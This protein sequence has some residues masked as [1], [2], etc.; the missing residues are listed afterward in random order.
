MKN[1]SNAD[2]ESIREKMLKFA[3]L[4]LKDKS[5]AEDMVQEAFVSALKNLSSFKRQSALKTWMFA[6]LKNKIID[7]LRTNQRF[8][9]ESDLV[10]EEEQENNFFERGMWRKEYRPSYLQEDENQIY[11]AQFWLVFESCLTHLPA[12]QAKI[13][14][15][16]EYL[17]LTAEE[18][19]HRENVS[20]SNLHVLLYRARL[21]LQHCLTRKIEAV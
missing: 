4:Q 17:E 20:T 5:V 15:M 21:Q 6:I 8:V 7:Y 13:F 18:I 14:M 11:S 10:D 1:L 16:R 3:E 12:L 2:L 19:C 9:L